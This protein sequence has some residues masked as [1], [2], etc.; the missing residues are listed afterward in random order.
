MPTK[1]WR[2]TFRAGIQR[3]S[4]I[5]YPMGHPQH[6]T[7]PPSWSDG[8]VASS[9]NS[10][11]VLTG[12][13]PQPWKQRI[14]QGFSAHSDMYGDTYNEHSIRNDGFV[15]CQRLQTGGAGL[16]QVRNDELRGCLPFYGNVGPKDP[17]QTIETV[18][19][20]VKM[21]VVSQVRAACTS[22][23]GM[24]ALGEMGQTLNLINGSARGIDRK[25]R[26]YLGSVGRQARVWR[27]L[28]RSAADKLDWI[29]KRWLEYSYGVKPLIN[30]V[31]SGA[32]A[33]ARIM[34]YRTPRVP[35]RAFSESS[36]NEEPFVV[37]RSFG[38]IVLKTKVHHSMTYS[39]RIYGS[40][41]LQPHSP[42]QFA[43][44]PVL[45]EAGIRLDEFFPTLWELI[46]YSF[47]VD[48]FSNIGAMID[49]ASLN[50]STISWLS[51]GY[52]C[53]QTVNGNVYICE[54]QPAS[55]GQRNLAL[56]KRLGKPFERSRSKINRSEFDPDFLVPSLEF[57]I[58]NTSTKWL[59][60][61]SLAILHRDVRVSLR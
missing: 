34:N 14:R 45:D 37:D 60:M 8:G 52:K 17:L 33:L 23:Q 51:S 31:K 39:Y 25:T 6:G 4:W 22:L 59:N 40:C 32:N 61:A 30:D 21:T 41:G 10:N 53:T 11:Q 28:R 46:P 47:L 24:V 2:S 36:Q 26:D 38:M 9:F 19:N 7:A 20:Q 29:S 12:T 15:S 3:R 35:I 16:G 57:K 43:R 18:R 55:A 42:S 54:Q 27:S 50:T 56:D 13:S 58:P 44:N 49:A 48:Y 5:E 1:T